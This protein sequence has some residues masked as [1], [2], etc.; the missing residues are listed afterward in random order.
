MLFFDPQFAKLGK[1]IGYEYN[2]FYD[3]TTAYH[4]LAAV[5]SSF[6]FV[7]LEYGTHC[8][9]SACLIAWAMKQLKK[10]RK[11]YTVDMGDQSEAKRWASKF[12]VSDMIEFRQSVSWEFKHEVEKYDF[13]FLDASHLTEDWEKEWNSILPYIH[14]KTL[15]AVHDTIAGGDRW[16]PL[17]D[18]LVEEFHPF[19]FPGKDGMTFL[20]RDPLHRV[21]HP[22]WIAGRM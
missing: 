3:P 2:G 19:T 11:L 9:W 17:E 7:A 18:K 6:P 10:S 22:T 5:Y 16:Q 21:S 15:I 4:L 14:D 8:G 12:A 20:R 1:E 13:I